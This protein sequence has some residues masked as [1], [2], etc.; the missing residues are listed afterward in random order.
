[1]MIS[2]S[3]LSTF[4]A[5]LPVGNTQTSLL[6]LF[7]RI[8]DRLECIT[9][10][11]LTSVYVQPDSDGMNDLMNNLQSSSTTT[12]PIVR[13]LAGG[14]QNT[15]GQLISSISQQL[16]QKNNENLYNTISSKEK[17]ELNLIVKR[18]GSRW[19][20]SC[21][22]LHFTTWKSTNTDCK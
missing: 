3:F 7:I 5:R 22:Y 16:N 11:D 1:M 18:I 15:V 14:N 2:F 4:E 6:H 12:N 8:R 20:T 9:E 21:E 17:I 13:L 10:F 19:Y